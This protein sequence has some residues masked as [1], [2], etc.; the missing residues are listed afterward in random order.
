MTGS[1]KA[2]NCSEQFRLDCTQSL[3]FLRN[4][5]KTNWQEGRKRKLS[6]WNL[7]S[8]LSFSFL[9]RPCLLPAPVSQLLREKK[10]TTCSLTPDPLSIRKYR[11]LLKEMTT[12]PRLN[13][14]APPGCSPFDEPVAMRTRSHSPK[15]PRKTQQRILAKPKAD[16]GT[17][18]RPPKRGYC[19]LCDVTYEEL[20]SHVNSKLHQA[21]AAKAGSFAGVDRLIQ[22]GRSLREF[23]ADVR[24]RKAPSALKRLVPFTPKFKRCIPPTF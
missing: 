21:G 24:A 22:R 14:D 10:G 3:S 7:F 16:E 19:E 18:R 17:K 11:P 20:R 8:L 9:A 2:R 12:W 15:S 4:T 6:I 1:T 23:V 13:L 5:T